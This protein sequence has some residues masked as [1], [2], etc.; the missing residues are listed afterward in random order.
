MS[1]AEGSPAQRWD[2]RYRALDRP[3]PGEVAPFLVEMAEH[4]PA[5]GTALDVGGGLGANARWLADHGLRVT[6][7]D[8]SDAGLD[9]A[10]GFDPGGRLDYV[11]R[12]VEADGLPP[13][14]W[15]VVL[16]HLFYDRALVVAAADHL[17]PGGVLLVCQPTETNLERHPRPSRRFLLGAGEVGQVAAELEAVGMETLVASAA[18][19]PSSRHDAWLVSRRRQR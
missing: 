13:G 6:L 5:A 15:D 10:R 8:V 4:L 3:E 17:A 11:R 16:F 9:I 7:L 18:W 14:E 2:D 19:R 12:D 1:K